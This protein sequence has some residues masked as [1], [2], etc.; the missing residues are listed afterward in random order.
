MF[1]YV[2]VLWYLS[3]KNIYLWIDLLGLPK[4]LSSLKRSVLL[5]DTGVKT[6][7]PLRQGSSSKS[8][9]LEV[10]LSIPSVS[11]IIWL[12]SSDEYLFFL[13]SPLFGHS[14]SSIT[15]SSSIIDP[16][17]GDLVSSRSMEWSC[18]F[19]SFVRCSHFWWCMRSL[20]SVTAL[21]DR[22]GPDTS[23]WSLHPSGAFFGNLEKMQWLLRLR[24]YEYE[25]A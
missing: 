22:F 10:T 24:L 17:K 21:I 12:Q 13:L 5:R 4:C 15:K 2:L 20:P 7:V 6:P 18:V 3:E 19:G 1:L 23:S 25:R 16:F 8:T 9:T 14:R 11:V